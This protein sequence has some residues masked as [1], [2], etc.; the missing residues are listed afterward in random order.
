MDPDEQVREVI[1]LIF[2]TYDALGTAWGVFRYLL[3]NDIRLGIRPHSGPNQGQLEWHRAS[4]MTVHR[5]LHHPIYAGVSAYGQRRRK[6]GRTAAGGSGEADTFLTR[7]EWKVFERDRLPAYITWDRYLANQERL[8]QNR[9]LPDTP[10]TPRQ[11][12]ALLAGLVV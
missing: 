12:I 9:C 8:R 2:D 3:G 1:R 10:G 5:I 6:H 4:F 11:G 7:H